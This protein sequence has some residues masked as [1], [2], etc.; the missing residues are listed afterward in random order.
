MLLLAEGWDANLTHARIY[1]DVPA[2]VVTVNGAVTYP[3]APLVLIL[4]EEI[5]ERKILVS[6]V[7]PV[8]LRKPSGPKTEAIGPISKPVVNSLD[9]NYAGG[10]GSTA[11]VVRSS[12]IANIYKAPAYLAPIARSQAINPALLT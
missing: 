12:A 5:P 6:L 2:T 7:T 10:Q 3:E 4:T 8:P 1:N 11:V 9:I